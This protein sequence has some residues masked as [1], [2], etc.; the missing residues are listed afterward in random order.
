[1]TAGIVAVSQPDRN[2]FG[3]SR[4]HRA[5][6]RSRP[7]PRPGRRCNLPDSTSTRRLVTQTDRPCPPAREPRRGS[8]P[9]PGHRWAG[10]WRTARPSG[11]APVLA[12]GLLAATAPVAVQLL[13]SPAAGA[14]VATHPG[15]G[16]LAAP[17]A[18]T[19]AWCTDHG[20]HLVAWS[21]T[22]PELPLCGPG[23]VDGGSWRFVVEPGEDGTVGAGDQDA[24]PGFQCVELAD[25]WLAVGEG[26]APVLAEGSQVAM[27]YHAAYP[28]RTTLVLNGSPAAVGHP[29]TAGDVISFSQVPDFDDPSDGHVAVVVWSR[30]D[31]RSGDGTVEIAQENVAEDAMRRSLRLEHWQLTDPAVPADAEWQWPYAEWLHV[32]VGPVTLVP[33]ATRAAIARERA[34]IA[35]LLRL[36]E[37]TQRYVVRA[38]LHRPAW[39]AVATAGAPK[40]TAALTAAGSARLVPAGAAAALALAGA[41]ARRARRSRRRRGAGLAG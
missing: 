23:P 2:P 18:T 16:P 25:R 38:F 4:P 6:L 22:F 32:V 26:L 1:V 37:P 13:A 30:W 33:A 36:G 5:F 28:R 41:T 20:S 19:P 11:R 40:G 24:T 8:F 29:P 39:E 3:L 14:V 10:R 15:D 12:L 34:K 21:G 17:E 9:R 31:R 35:A 7:P 27:N